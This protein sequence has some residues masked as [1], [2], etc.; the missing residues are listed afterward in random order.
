MAKVITNGRCVMCGKENVQ[1][2]TLDN[3]R[4]VVAAYLCDT[5]AAP[6]LAI[7][8]AA[9]DLPPDQQIP[10]PE[11]GGEPLGNLDIHK[12]GRRD[13]RM[14]PL[15]WTPP[16]PPATI[17]PPEPK[18]LT[19]LDLIVIQFREEGMAW[20]GVGKALGMSRQAAYERFRHL[21]VKKNGV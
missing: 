16:G 1:L 12:R 8:D 19:D 5:D 21:P 18:E 11:R 4:R 20:K 6:L 10:I 2:W 7:M 3:M 14:E 13:V 15:E 9:G 17:A